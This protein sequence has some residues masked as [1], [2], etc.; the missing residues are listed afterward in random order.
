MI[1][2]QPDE[3][4][5][6]V[7]VLHIVRFRVGIKSLDLWNGVNMVAMMMMMWNEVC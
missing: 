4:G 6:I 3:L 7:L 5:R 1:E 2:R